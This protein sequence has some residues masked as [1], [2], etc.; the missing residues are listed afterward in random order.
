MKLKG[1]F[2]PLVAPLNFQKLTI[3]TGLNNEKEIRKE[4][5]YENKKVRKI[6]DYVNW[7]V[8]EYDYSNDMLKVK[9]YRFEDLVD[10]KKIHS[11]KEFAYS[12][13]KKIREVLV[14]VNEG[15][16]ELVYTGNFEYLGD[17]LSFEHFIYEDGEQYRIKHEWN[18]KRS[19]NS[20]IHLD[21]PDYGR[22]FFDKNG[23]LI[24]GL[25]FKYEGC[26]ERTLYE[27]KGGQLFKMVEYPHLEYKKTLLGKIKIIGKAQFMNETESYYYD[28]GLLKKEVIKDF[29]TKEVVNTLYYEYE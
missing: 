6:I 21:E 11:F 20:I 17:D 12:S 29:E 1:H 18:K 24:E 13:G 3:F 10:N 8:S 23:Y 14:E 5:F 19:I 28:S 27:Y 15:D 2:D 9:F 22:Y 26:V 16:E 7:I 4:Y 25:S